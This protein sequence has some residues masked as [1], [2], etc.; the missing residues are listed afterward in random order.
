MNTQKTIISDFNFELPYHRET[1]GTLMNGYIADEMGG[2]D[3]LSPQ[4][5]IELVEGLRNHPKAIAILAETD[6][7]PS[8]LIVAF[9]NF[10]TFSVRPMLNI[11][12]VFVVPEFRGLGIGRLLM[13]AIVDKAKEHKCSRISLEVRHDNTTAQKLYQSIDFH[14]T[15]PPMYFWRK[16]L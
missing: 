2:G 4:Q 12:D 14:D 10:S 1:M 5:Q 11:H 16:Y 13:N 15:E 8:G 7:K 6:G 9:E 3:L